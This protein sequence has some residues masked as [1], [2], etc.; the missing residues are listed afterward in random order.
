L[1]WATDVVRFVILEPTCQCQL[2]VSM[3]SLA[4]FASTVL[5]EA[6]A[7]GGAGAILTVVTLAFAS[8][9]L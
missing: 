8:A 2:V 3:R 4:A 5:G 7:S 6:F 1:G 9:R